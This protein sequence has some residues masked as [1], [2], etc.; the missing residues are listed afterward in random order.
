M[1][2]A[3]QKGKTEGEEVG[4]LREQIPT[5][6]ALLSGNGGSLCS[7]ADSIAE[8]AVPGNQESFSC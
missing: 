2:E 7:G 6:K 5:R 3:L 8:G 1:E 4:W